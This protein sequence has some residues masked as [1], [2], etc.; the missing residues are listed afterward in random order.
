[1]SGGLGLGI[2]DLSVRFGSLEVLRSIS[3]ELTSGVTAL[4]GVN[5][6]GKS[7]LLRV[8]AGLLAPTAGTVR[9]GERGLRQS[10]GAVLRKVGYL[11]E[12]SPL[13]PYLT[14]LEYLEMV[15]TLRDQP[16]DR[17]SLL[18]QL[19]P[20]GV[21]EHGGRLIGDLSLGLRRRSALAGA[22]LGDPPV[23]L[24]DEPLSGLDVESARAM[25]HRLS[26][27]ARSGAVVLWATHRMEMV[28]SLAT[29]VLVVHGGRVHCD[30]SPMALRQGVD[31]PGASFEEV[32]FGLLALPRAG[33]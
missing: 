17:A 8:L 7:T 13:P 12:S 11:P 16:T 24:L 33:D 26:E 18:A 25:R 15:A 14:P 6:A 22:L 23:L 10:R 19:E 31:R 30:G 28:E 5:G 1:M 21:A 29:R 20:L 27:R 4:L 9:L 3:V 32:F 2:Q